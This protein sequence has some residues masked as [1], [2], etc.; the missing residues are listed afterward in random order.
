MCVCAVVIAAAA[1]CVVWELIHT[2]IFGF[3]YL[4]EYFFF[5]L[6]FR[7]FDN[8]GLVFWGGPRAKIEILDKPGWCN[9]ESCDTFA[10]GEATGG[11]AEP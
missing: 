5:I 10:L 7:K 8:F 1:V 4:Y 6:F 2:L 11:C 9:L 3:F